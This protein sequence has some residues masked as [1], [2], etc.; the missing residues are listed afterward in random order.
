MRMENIGKVTNTQMKLI[1]AVGMAARMTGIPRDIRSSHPF[2]GYKN[3][4]ISSDTLKT[5]MYGLVPIYESWKLKIRLRLC[6]I[7]S[8]N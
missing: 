7:L 2:A 1:G 4:S 6:G 8:Q 3:Y 5:E